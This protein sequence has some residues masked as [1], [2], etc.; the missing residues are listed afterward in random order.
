MT[1]RDQLIRAIS[2]AALPR[3]DDVF[4]GAGYETNNR[5]LTNADAACR[6]YQLPKARA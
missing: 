3:H 6:A 4:D 1:D 2:L 5:G